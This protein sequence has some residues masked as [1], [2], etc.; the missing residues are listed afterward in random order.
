MSSVGWLTYA[1]TIFILIAA[2]GYLL[3][4]KIV[5]VNWSFG[6]YFSLVL[7]LF[8]IGFIIYSGIKHQRKQAK[9]E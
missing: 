5:G 2:G 3:Y 8:V 1:G 9:L 6:E 4:K 7:I